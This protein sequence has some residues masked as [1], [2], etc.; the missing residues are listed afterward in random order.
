MP[1]LFNPVFSNV[2]RSKQIDWVKE[3]CDEWIV[4]PSLTRGSIGPDGNDL[5][6]TINRSG[7]MVCMNH[8]TKSSN[9]HFEVAH[10]TSTFTSIPVD[11]ESHVVVLTMF[12]SVLSS[13]PSSQTR[14]LE[15]NNI[16]GRDDV[17]SMS[18]FARFDFHRRDRL[19]SRANGHWL[20][21]S[22]FH[23]SIHK[24]WRK[25]DRHLVHY[26][27]VHRWDTMLLTDLLWINTV[28]T[29]KIFGKSFLFIVHVWF[30]EWAH[31]RSWEWF[32]VNH[33]SLRSSAFHNI[34]SRLLSLRHPK[35]DSPLV[36]TTN[37]RSRSSTS[38][39]PVCKFS[40]GPFLQ[41]F[42]RS[43]LNAMIMK[44]KE[45]HWGLL[46]FSIDSKTH[47]RG[48]ETFRP[49]SSVW[50]CLFSLF[51]VFRLRMLKK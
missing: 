26:K 7:A 32:W 46:L 11:F 9:F 18:F 37:S 4:Q 20:A 45:Q 6:M 16:L 43:P 21:F 10:S 34:A 14:R 17:G 1:I 35:Q 23:V 8:S 47:S 12:S 15:K 27:Y 22:R 3:S 50:T 40:A 38:S 29:D 2:I 19:R 36:L 42:L 5:L 30:A 31:I 39:A 25:K 48:D 28:Q 49:S 41:A 33:R 24:R 44:I 13:T 51:T